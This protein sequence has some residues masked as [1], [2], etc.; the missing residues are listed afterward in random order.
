MLTQKI[1][2]VKTLRLQSIVESTNQENPDLLRNYQNNNT[3]ARR[4]QDSCRRA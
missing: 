4:F 3:R 1:E 2:S